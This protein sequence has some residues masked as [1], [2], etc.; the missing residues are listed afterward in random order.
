MNK[1]QKLWGVILA[2]IFFLWF[3]IP[4]DESNSPYLQQNIVEK[5]TERPKDAVQSLIDSG[6]IPALNYR[7]SDEAKARDAL[8]ASA[9]SPNE[10]APMVFPTQQVK[11]STERGLLPLTVGIAKTK[12]QWESG[13]MFY[14][15]WPGDKMHGLLF[16]FK[17]PAVLTMWMKNTFIPL[18]IVF[19]DAEGKIINIHEQAKPLSQ[20]TIASNAPALYVLELPAGAARNW[21]IA[22]GDR[23]LYTEQPGQ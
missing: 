22:A 10:P 17:D 1:K 5:P 16:I 12:V 2:F 18:D 3:M 19:I 13:M 20:D 14:R 23:L 4:D 6:D 15:Q 7:K 9:A 11:I 21:Q 8:L